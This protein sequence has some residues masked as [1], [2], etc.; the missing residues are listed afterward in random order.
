MNRLLYFCRYISSTTEAWELSSLA[1][2]VNNMYSHLMSLLGACHKHIGSSHMNNCKTIRL[3]YFF[4]LSEIVVF[5]FSTIEGKMH[6]ETYQLLLHLFE[7]SHIDNMKVLRALLNSRDDPQPI[8]DG[9]SKRR[10]PSKS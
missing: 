3:R 4:F 5:R 7:M 1:H 6:L 10:V 2:K 9:A 8:I